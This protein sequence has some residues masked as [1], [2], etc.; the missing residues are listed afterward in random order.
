[1]HTLVVEIKLIKLHISLDND[2]VFFT[3]FALKMHCTEQF[4]FI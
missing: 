1:M 4:L 2:I 3:T